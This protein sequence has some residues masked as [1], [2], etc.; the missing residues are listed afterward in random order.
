MEAMKRLDVHSTWVIKNNTKFFPKQA[1]RSVLLARHGSRPAGQ[2]V[3]FRTRIAGVELFATI[4]AWSQQSASY[5]I[6]TCG[7]TE[8]SCAPYQSWFEDDFG[9]AS[10]KELP[11][12][13]MAEFLYQYLPLI[14]EHNKQR[15]SELALEKCWPTS[16]CWF[17]LLVTIVGMSVV[18]L[19]RIYKFKDKKYEDVTIK[20]FAD[21]IAKGLKLRDR[22]SNHI[23]LNAD[24]CLSPMIGSDGS[25]FRDPSPAEKRQKKKRVPIAGSCWVCKKYA[26]CTTD[27]HPTPWVCK[28]CGTPICRKD[29]RRGQSCIQEHI[30]GCDPA[31]RCNGK[32]MGSGQHSPSKKKKMH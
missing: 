11:R 22:P 8:T 6:S 14:D 27:Y 20:E 9:G 21:R 30:N 28:K 15:Q 29:R 25:H 24:E 12:L 17:R 7:S 1:L 23:A 31:T 18:D 10:S 13:E 2:W 5:F 19:H 26:T 4:Y 3:V 32:K 16:D